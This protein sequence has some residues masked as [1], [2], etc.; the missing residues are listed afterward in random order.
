MTSMKIFDIAASYWDANLPWGD[1]I[2]DQRADYIVGGL[3]LVLSFSLQ[4]AANLVSSSAA[5]SLLQPYGFAIAEISAGIG[6][7][8]GCSVFLRFSIAKKTRRE[9]RRLVAE[10]LA[11]QALKAKSNVPS[12]V[13]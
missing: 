2:A 3:L 9:V 10:V 8:L 11:E 7:L 12:P 4:L 1:S 6:F 13:L 5:P